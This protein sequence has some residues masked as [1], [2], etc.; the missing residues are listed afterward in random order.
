MKTNPLYG[1]VLAI[2]LLAGTATYSLAQTTTTTAADQTT[3]MV[4]EDDGFDLGWLGL[5]GLLGLAG[6]K[7]RDRPV[8]TTTNRI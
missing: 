4:E 5:L 3:D 6:L 8:T 7:R 1:S 2:I